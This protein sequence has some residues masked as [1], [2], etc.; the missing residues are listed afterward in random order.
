VTVRLW[1]GYLWAGLVTLA[2]L[3]VLAVV[4]VASF[5]PLIKLNQGLSK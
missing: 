5:V 1:P 4:L 3:I 2:T